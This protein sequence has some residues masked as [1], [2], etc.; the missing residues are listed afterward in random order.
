MG[1]D[2]GDLSTV[3]LCSMPPAQSQ[4]LQRAGRAGC[5][6]GNSLTLAIA[7]AKLHDLY[8]YEDPMDM[9]AGNVTPPKIFLK[10]SAVL[11]RQF[12]AFCMDSW[13]K[14]GISE[15]VIPDKTGVI[16]KK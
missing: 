9:I 4:F 1:I 13:V 10:A 8:F 16:L 6:D 15:E 2:I 11:E 7:N 5:K 12:V 14:E 3:I